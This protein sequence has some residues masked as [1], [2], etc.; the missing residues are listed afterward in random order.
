[1]P[2]HVLASLLRTPVN[3][4]NDLPSSIG[5][6]DR[7]SPALALGILH[8]LFNLDLWP[9][10]GRLD[11]EVALV[12]RVEENQGGGVARKPVEMKGGVDGGLR[13]ADMERSIAGESV[14]QE[15]T[16]R[17]VFSGGEEREVGVNWAVGSSDEKL[18]EIGKLISFVVGVLFRIVREGDV[19][20][21]GRVSG[22]EY[23]ELGSGEV[24]DDDVVVGP[25]FT[26]LNAQTL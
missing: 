13:K 11:Q 5:D 6:I 14:D 10:E 4:S 23:Q 25:D 15:F 1:M 17:M 19:D 18:G 22:L 2:K 12:S 9:E 20:G 26:T 24:A 3:L 16:P 8:V 7:S 21:D